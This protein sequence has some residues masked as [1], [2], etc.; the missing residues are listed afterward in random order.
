VNDKGDACWECLHCNN[1]KHSGVN[2]T[3]VLLHVLKIQGQNVRLCRAKIPL[4]YV[5]HYEN[6]YCT[7]QASKKERQE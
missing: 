4:E 1:C 2:A 6:L 5:R 7:T 3:K